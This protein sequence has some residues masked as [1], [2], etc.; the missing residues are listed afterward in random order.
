[1]Q[2]QLDLLPEPSDRGDL[3]I[4]DRAVEHVVTAAAL[5]ADGVR[6][7]GTGLARLAGRDLPR[8][9][10][11]VAG[12]RVLAEV[13]IAVEWGRS[14]HAV[15]ASVQHDVTAALSN[16]CGLRVD[17]V[18]VHVAEIVEPVNNSSARR[19]LQ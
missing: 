13:E 18:S 3:I 9:T 19:N 12:D 16:D 4:R 1:M 10:V 14:L 6:R 11:S 5:G 15:T 7:H 8:A 2:P 17:A